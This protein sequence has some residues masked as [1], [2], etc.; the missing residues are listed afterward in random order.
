MDRRVGRGAR[1]IV[2]ENKKQ[3]AV[4]ECL[5]DVGTLNHVLLRLLR[6]P[7]YRSIQT[8]PTSPGA[9]RKYPNIGLIQMSLSG[10]RNSFVVS[11]FELQGKPQLRGKTL[12]EINETVDRLVVIAR[13]AVKDSRI[14]ICLEDMLLWYS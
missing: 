11:A 13:K 5:Q 14:R 4:T 12:Q 1:T 8:L 10:G 3:L 6:P 9:F 2:A 7:V